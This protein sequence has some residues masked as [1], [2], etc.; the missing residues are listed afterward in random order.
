MTTRIDMIMNVI[1]QDI[2]TCRTIL[3]HKLM[4]ILVPHILCLL[5]FPPVS[6]TPNDKCNNIFLTR[7]GQ[8]RIVVFLVVV[9]RCINNWFDVVVGEFVVDHVHFVQRQMVL[10]DA[11]EAVRP[12]F[13]ADGEVGLKCHHNANSILFNITNTGRLRMKSTQ[14]RMSPTITRDG[15]G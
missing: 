15:G 12:S 10:S 3:L 6:K 11:R 5:R 14:C 9:E 2:A 13:P 7:F 8:G 1:I 4:H